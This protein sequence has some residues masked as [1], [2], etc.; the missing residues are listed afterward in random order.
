MAPVPGTSNILLSTNS[1]KIQ[2]RVESTNHIRIGPC[3]YHSLI[4][5]GPFISIFIYLATIRVQD[6][7]SSNNKTSMELLNEIMNYS[8]NDED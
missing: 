3:Q 2:E 8:D 6:S 1:E 4:W 7:P 5:H